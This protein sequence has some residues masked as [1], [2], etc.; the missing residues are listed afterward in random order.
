MNAAALLWALLAALAAMGAVAVLACASSAAM[1]RARSAADLEALIDATRED[2][3]D[4]I[5]AE[6]TEQP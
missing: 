3:P 4:F 2:I 5:P 1:R 6:W